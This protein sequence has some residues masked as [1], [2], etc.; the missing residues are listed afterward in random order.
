MDLGRRPD[1]AVPTNSSG[2]FGNKNWGLGPSVVVLHLDK[3]SP[4]VYGVLVNNIWS[5]TSDK[6]GGCVQQRPDPAIRQ[7]QLRRRRCI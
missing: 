5:L 6:Q 4:W 2:E 3:G 1:R 7:L